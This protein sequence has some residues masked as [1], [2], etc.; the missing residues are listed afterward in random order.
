MGQRPEFML[1]STIFRSWKIGK[2]IPKITVEVI[3]GSIFAVFFLSEEMVV[4][5]CPKKVFNN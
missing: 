5:V 1:Q 2:R 3:S 4:H